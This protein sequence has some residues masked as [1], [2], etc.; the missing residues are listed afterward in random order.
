MCWSTRIA[1]LFTSACSALTGVG[2]SERDAELELDWELHDA[3]LPSVM[4]D[5]GTVP[6]S[7]R[8][9]S[10]EREEPAESRVRQKPHFA[11]LPAAMELGGLEPPTSWVRSRRF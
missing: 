5:M 7:G 6:N 9:R 4:K 1:W 8:R 11:G 3:L 2:S 10:R